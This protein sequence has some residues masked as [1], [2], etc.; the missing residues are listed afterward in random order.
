MHYGE[1]SVIVQFIP[2]RT[3]CIFDVVFVSLGSP[4][5]IVDCSLANTDTCTATLRYI[6]KLVLIDVDEVAG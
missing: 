6:F 1:G 3:T 5:A 2:H 4:R